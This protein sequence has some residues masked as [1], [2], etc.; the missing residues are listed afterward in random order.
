MSIL[1]MGMPPNQVEMA[2]LAMCGRCCLTQTS[3]KSPFQRHTP[4]GRSGPTQ[5]L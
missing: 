3:A 4:Q 1:L 5:V 2:R